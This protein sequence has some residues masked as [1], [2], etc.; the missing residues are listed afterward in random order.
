MRIHRK[1]MAAAQV[2]YLVIPRCFGVV[3]GTAA[4]GSGADAVEG[5]L[6]ASPHLEVQMMIRHDAAAGLLTRHFNVLPLGL[7]VVEVTREV[8]VMMVKEVR[9]GGAGIG[10]GGRAVTPQVH[11][12]PSPRPGGILLS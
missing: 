9:G 11:A 2:R 1:I 8:V 5:G 10:A 3:G 12:E 7:V 4:V 6:G